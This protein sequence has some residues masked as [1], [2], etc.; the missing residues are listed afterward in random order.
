MEKNA[1]TRARMKDRG[2]GLVRREKRRESEG[3]GRMC[4]RTSEGGGNGRRVSRWHASTQPPPHLMTRREEGEGPREE[5]GRR[6][7]AGNRGQEGRRCRGATDRRT[8]GGGPSRQVQLW[9]LLVTVRA[10]GLSRNRPASR[11]L[12]PPPARLRV[13]NPAVVHG[14]Q[15]WSSGDLLTV[16]LAMRME[17]P[18][19]HPASL[20]VTCRPGR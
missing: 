2:P 6:G 4:L 7:T 5:D 18:S 14:H 1:R 16:C 3:G 8:D 15:C 20:T 19:R 13:E 9:Q 10:V 11:S 17:G 12:V